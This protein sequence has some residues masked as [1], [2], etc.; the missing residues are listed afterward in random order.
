MCS[1]RFLSDNTKMHAFLSNPHQTVDLKK[2]NGETNTLLYC[3]ALLR[4]KMMNKIL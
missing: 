1:P 3:V 4:L 2:C